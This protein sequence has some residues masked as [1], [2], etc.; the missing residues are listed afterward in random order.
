MPRR[1]TPPAKRPATAAVEVG[2]ATG[3]GTG[4]GAVAAVVVF[5]LA[6][7][8]RVL[9]LW[10]IRRA[11]FLSLLMGDALS[12]DLWAQRIASGEWLGREV[13]YQAPL[14]PYLLG[15]LYRIVG[16]DPVAARI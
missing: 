8:V 4:T 9:H 6:L 5:A 10:Q 16:H 15:V 13:F 7:A 1:R 11:P 3:T 14:Y 2:T 12:Y